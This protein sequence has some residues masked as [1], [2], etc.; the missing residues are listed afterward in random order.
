M[1]LPARVQGLPAPLLAA[2]DALSTRLSARPRLRRGLLALAAAGVLAA[3]VLLVDD[4][5]ERARKRVRGAARPVAR[6]VRTAA[7]SALIV[8]D[9]KL[10]LAGLDAD[11]TQY[12]EARDAAHTRTAKRL[13][14][15]AQLQG[16][17]FIKAGQHL[18]SLNHVLPR[19]ITDTLSV[20]QNAAP[21]RP[22]GEM[23]P[24][25]EE[26][27]G[28]PLHSLFASFDEEP[29]ASASLAQVHRAR[30]LDGEELAVK[31]QY[32]LLR[33]E[34]ASD[35]AT[36]RVL[37]RSV[38]R[39]FRD[40]NLEW[41]V[42]AFEENVLKELDFVR[43]GRNSERVAENFAHRPN[44]YVPRIRW[45]LSTSRVLSMEFIHGSK[46]TEASAIRAMGFEPRAVA[47]ELAELFGEMI[48]HQGFVHCDPHPGNLLVRPRPS[49]PRSFQLVLLDHGLYRELDEGFRRSYARLWSS[50]FYRDTPGLRRACDELGVGRYYRVFP[51][52]LTYRP[53]DS[54]AGLGEQLSEEERQR[55]RG[56]LASYGFAE[57]ND[58]MASLPQDMLFVLRTHNLV[59]SINQELGGT[60]RDRLY[61]M[62]RY[63]TSAPEHRRVGRRPD[64]LWSRLRDVAEST[65][66][67]LRFFVYETLLMALVRTRARFGGQALPSYN[68]SLFDPSQA[69]PAPASAAAPPA[70]PS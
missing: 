57:F 43:E 62:F 45:G 6:F 40:V 39:V 2:R 60:T 69:T 47:S 66:F 46:V 63:A 10:S 15:L 33:D 16:G 65:A 20:L 1:R 38:S 29:I 11:S 7:V 4:W 67:S 32:P 50:L 54:K 35:L 61:T 3:P 56:K 25:V 68:R 59:R 5:R 27:L 18:A 51:L 55:V 22:F 64:D 53:H 31:I 70:L 52:V 13:L 21:W 41:I 58:F 36:I 9:Y 37:T 19:S 48:F 12:R 44:L 24:L 14:W 8:A 17:L 28:A 30:A 23:R 26:E 42:S 34:L 49:D